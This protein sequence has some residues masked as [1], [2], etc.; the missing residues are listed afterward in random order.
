M[1]L[2]LEAKI[3]FL[4]CSF[5]NGHHTNSSQSDLASFLFYFILDALFDQWESNTELSACQGQS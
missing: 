3:D 2:A 1:C 4:F 5:L